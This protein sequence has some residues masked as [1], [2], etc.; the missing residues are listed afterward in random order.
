MSTPPDRPDR[1][2]ALERA[3]RAHSNESPPPAL[4]RAILAAAHRAVGSRPEA[5]KPAEATSPQRWWMPLAAAATIGAVV[6]GIMQTMPADTNVVAP[7]AS[8]PAMAPRPVGKLA[9]TAP[10]VD[11][12]K[13]ESG[14]VAA[15]QKKKQAETPAAPPAP[16]LRDSAAAVAE[17]GSAAASAAQSRPRSMGAAPP[18]AAPVPAPAAGAASPPA[19]AMKNDVARAPEPFPAA[20]APSSAESDARKDAP[21][22][23]QQAAAPPSPALAGRLQQAPAAPPVPAPASTSTMRARDEVRESPGKPLAKTHA[24]AEDPQAKAR[25]PEAWIARIRKLRDEGHAAEALR[26]LREFRTTVPDAERRL[27]TDLREWAATVKP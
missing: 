12:R 21:S 16:A 20:S 15:E 26:E 18:A 24:F 11:A 7:E 17:R 13:E 3:W 27:P 8:A 19:Q 10:S 23:R 14:S 1:D 5:A 9:A 22:E 25:D 4:D 2:P 6:I